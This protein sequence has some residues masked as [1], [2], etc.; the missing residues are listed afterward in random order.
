M[1]DFR[2]VS[3]RAQTA[4]D[5]EC[6][7]SRGQH[8]CKFIGT[9]ES[10]YIRKEF[11]SHRISLEHQHGRRFIILY[12][13]R[14]VMYKHSCLISNRV[15]WVLVNLLWNKQHEAQG[16][17]IYRILKFGLY[18]PEP[19]L[20]NETK[21]GGVEGGGE[22]NKVHYGRCASITSSTILIATKKTPQ[23]PAEI[24]W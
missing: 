9:K 20:K 14:D 19:I 6:F 15:G 24:A 13:H 12:G 8:L 3:L 2:V 5:T 4:F 23:Y 10:V 17:E 22:A 1:P 18:R 7:H 11:N 16:T 21:S